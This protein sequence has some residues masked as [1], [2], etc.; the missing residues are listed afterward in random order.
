[1]DD[2]LPRR[3]LHLLA[4]AGLR[5]QALPADANG[6][7]MQIAPVETLT[8]AI[9]TIETFNNGDGSSLPTC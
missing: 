8:D 4:P 7:D 2:D 3:P 6:G 9:E 1:V 5:M